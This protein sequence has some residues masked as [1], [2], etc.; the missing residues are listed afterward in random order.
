MA[1]GCVGARSLPARKSNNS[2]DL[3]PPA[4][5]LVDEPDWAKAQ[6]RALRNFSAAGNLAKPPLGKPTL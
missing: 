4:A 6:S 5:V 3:R 2:A 1:C